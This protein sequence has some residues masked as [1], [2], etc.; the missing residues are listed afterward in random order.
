MKIK[1]LTPQYEKYSTLFHSKAEVEELYQTLS[2]FADQ[3][4]LSKSKGMV[5]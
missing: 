1:K 5:I 3:N 4:N 2:E